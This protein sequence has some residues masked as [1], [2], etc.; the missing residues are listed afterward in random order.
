MA[1]SVV[2]AFI[3]FCEKNAERIPAAFQL[4]VDRL[5]EFGD[6]LAPVVM[7]GSKRNREFYLD[8]ILALAVSADI[9]VR[10]QAIMG[11]GHIAWEGADFSDNRTREVL[12]KTIKDGKD[13]RVLAAAIRA[14]FALIRSDK[15]HRL[16]LHSLVI[17]A[18]QQG[19]RYSLHAGA[20]QVMF[21][22]DSLDDDFLY[23]AL[24][25]L[26]RVAPTD[27]GTI[28]HIDYGLTKLFDS[29]RSDIGLVFLERL[30]PI[31]QSDADLFDSTISRIRQDAL[32]CERAITRWFVSGNRALCEAAVALVGSCYPE[33][34]PLSIDSAELPIR[35]REH[36]LFLARKVI[37]YLFIYPGTVVG[38]IVSIMRCTEDQ[39]ILDEFSRLLFESLL[40]NYPGRTRE[41]LEIYE[42]QEAGR[43]K[44]A[45]SQ[46]LSYLSDYR[47]GIEETPELAAL[48]VS[49]SHREIRHRYESE[50]MA[51]S[52]RAAEKKSTFFNLVS[53]SILLYGRKSI[54][55]VY[56]S[57]GEKP[58]RQETPLVTHS[59]SSEYPG[60][61]VFD[62]YDLHYMINVFC[63]EKAP[64]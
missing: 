34:P 11:L 20:Q 56:T 2:N 52:M 7:I 4:I 25:Q 21:D 48:H 38:L 31:Y 37:G 42:S 62:P 16:E 29:N 39:E 26:E 57:P 64:G 18:M 54:N 61:E 49:Q 47:S 32:L 6:L 5:S 27:T 33:V 24:E 13:D 35:D 55:Y 44:A 14:T 63:L 28:D 22:I 51:K 23:L 9:D 3:D 60:M 59:F 46:A 53:R 50:S 40:I 43:V 45:I 10:R 8:G 58:H 12:A 41:C 30:L 36:L 17:Q 1:G 19:A 15:E